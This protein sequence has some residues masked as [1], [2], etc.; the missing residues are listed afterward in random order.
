MGN[1]NGC[2]LWGRIKAVFV[3]LFYCAPPGPVCE[4]LL[5][6]LSSCHKFGPSLGGLEEATTWHLGQHLAEATSWHLGQHQCVAD[7]W[8]FKYL[9][10][11]ILIR[12]NIRFILGPQIY[13]DNNLLNFLNFYIVNI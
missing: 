5:Y 7:F 6:M 12:Q 11:N 8:I 4:A 10:M 13:L 9:L 2:I 1:Y 3:A